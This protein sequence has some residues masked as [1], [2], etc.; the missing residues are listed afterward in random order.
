MGV[1]RGGFQSPGG[2]IWGFLKRRGSLCGSSGCAESPAGVGSLSARKNL[3]ERKRP[4]A[5]ARL[6]ALWL[7]FG[8]GGGG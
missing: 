8:G 3:P 4:P 2:R 5:R 7:S 6:P 1:E